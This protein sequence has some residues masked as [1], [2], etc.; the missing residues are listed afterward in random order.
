M[1]PLGRGDEFEHR[2][3]VAE[4]GVGVRHVGDGATVGLQADRRE[5]RATAVLGAAQPE[6][7][8]RLVGEI[9]EIVAFPI[10][11]VA[12]GLDVVVHPLELHIGH[13]V[14]D[15][16]QWPS[17]LSQRGKQLLAAVRIT[18]PYESDTHHGIRRT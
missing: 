6:G 5:V 2:V 1:R 14:D 10:A 12:V 9:G 11:P 8:D 15:L 13:L 16:G 4:G 17:Q 3:A 7:L 18:D